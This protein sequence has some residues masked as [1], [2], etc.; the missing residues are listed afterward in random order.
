MPN[1]K[2][3]VYLILLAF[4]TAVLVDKCPQLFGQQILNEVAIDYAN[5]KFKTINLNDLIIKLVSA[6]IIQP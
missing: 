1:T 6:L 2:K 5:V 4:V 3:I